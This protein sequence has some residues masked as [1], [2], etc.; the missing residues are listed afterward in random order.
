MAEKWAYFF[1]E[2]EDLTMVPDARSEPPFADALEVARAGAFSETEWEGYMA[3]EIALQNERGLFSLARKE[4]KAEGRL[5]AKIE[6]L[7]QAIEAMCDILAIELTEE[8]RSFLA[9]LDASGHES[10]L[11]GLRT[12]RR[13]P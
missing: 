1:R 13:W 12:D 3:A 2:A 4:G 5:E 7:V 6:G 10:V 11:A 9:T 8:R